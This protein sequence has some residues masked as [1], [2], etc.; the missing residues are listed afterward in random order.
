MSSGTSIEDG[1]VFFLGAGFSASAGVPLTDSLL[2]KTL[3]L[4][5]DEC[6]GLYERVSGYAQDVDLNSA[7]HLSAEDFSSF[8]TYLDSVEL[9]E[10]GGSER[11]SE[12]GSRE[13]LALKFFSRRQLLFTP[14]YLTR[15][16][17]FTKIFA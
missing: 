3:D 9:R 15:R 11:W 6:P 10:Y 16:L 4:F 8:S 1:R 13:R 5:R 2:P 17:I 14:H 7:A 12:Q